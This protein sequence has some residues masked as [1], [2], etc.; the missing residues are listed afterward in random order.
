MAK[1]QNKFNIICADPCWDFKDQLKMDDVARGATSNYKTLSLE[2]IKALK[3]PSICADDAL[4]ALW[5]PSSLLQDGLDTMKA[6]GFTQ[7]QTLPW[8]KLKKHKDKDIS[9]QIFDVSQEIFKDQNPNVK[10][11]FKRNFINKVSAI[12]NDYDMENS[13]AFGMGRLFRQSHEIILIGTRGKINS[14]LKNKSQRSVIFDI[15]Y[16]H[17]QKPETLQDKLEKMFPLADGNKYLELFARR[18][19]KDWVCLGN[20]VCNGEDITDSI[21][22]L[23]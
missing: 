10:A 16:R 15:N 2:Q 6:W 5:V 22:K 3:V 23:L 7:K 17:S 12:I 14:K 21:Q 9:K 4:L 1:V 8:V 11:A 13:L 20:E 18:L 19:R